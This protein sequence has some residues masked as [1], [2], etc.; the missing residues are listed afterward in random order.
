[1]V[2]Q[3]IRAE[4]EARLS[5]AARNDIERDLLAGRLDPWSAADRILDGR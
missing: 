1:V 5:A 2:E 3:R 4:A